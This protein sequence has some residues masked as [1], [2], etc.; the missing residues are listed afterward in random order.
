MSFQLSGMCCA[1]YISQTNASRRRRLCPQ[2]LDS[3]DT[4]AKVIMY[5]VAV[6]KRLRSPAAVYVLRII[7]TFQ[8]RRL[9]AGS[10]PL[11]RHVCTP[12]FGSSAVRASC[13]CRKLQEPSGHSLFGCLSAYV[14][15]WTV[16]SVSTNN[17][18]LLPHSLSSTTGQ[19]MV[20]AKL[21]EAII[22]WHVL[23]RARYIL[24]MAS[25]LW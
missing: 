5:M 24:R 22:A 23:Q 6:E 17:F 21:A 10:A 11:R 20:K 2:L 13:R 4:G 12:L 3:C 8:E 14:G 16:A 9:A 7:F 18:E 1:V 15:R 19:A 25:S